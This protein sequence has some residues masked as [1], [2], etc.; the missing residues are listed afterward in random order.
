[1]PNNTLYLVACSYTKQEQAAP[2]KELYASPLFTMS[3]RYVERTG[4]GWAILSAKHG[5]VDPNDV[6][7]PYNSYLAW[8]STDERK[9][10]AESLRP[11][12]L[13]RLAFWQA[14]TVVF[15]AGTLYREHL[16]GWLYDQNIKVEI[17]MA[18][19]GIG[20]QLGWLRTQLGR[21]VTS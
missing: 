20:E 21:R 11:A 19:L 10:W 9:A 6:I 2:A 5:V 16:S 7:E 17:P 15:L 18:G 3:R 4:A 8:W 14:T 13:K 12:L 1:M